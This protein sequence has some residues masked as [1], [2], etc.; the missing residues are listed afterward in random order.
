MSW[1]QKFHKQ[2]VGA[3]IAAETLRTMAEGLEWCSNINVEPPLEIIPMATGPFIR[4]AGWFF[5]AYVG[6]VGSGGISARA[7]ATPG[8]G[9]VD[10]MTYN[11]STLVS[12][13]A[14]VTALSISST[15]GG[16]PEGTYCI[17][18]RI[19]GVFWLVSVDCGN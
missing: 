12:F 1:K 18:L 5:A 6:T 9:T 16:I 7:S 8:S 3:P 15:T 2:K 14:S 11:G 10:L 17:V 19:F 4:L 13:G